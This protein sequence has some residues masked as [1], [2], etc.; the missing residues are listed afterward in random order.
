M[1]RSESDILEFACMLE[2]LQTVCDCK[3][4]A[5]IGLLVGGLESEGVGKLFGARLARLRSFDVESVRSSGTEHLYPTLPLFSTG[6]KQLLRIIYRH[7]ISNV[8][9]IFLAFSS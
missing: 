7:K 4:G 6:L 9:E 2:M 8:G 1:G 5:C 3:R